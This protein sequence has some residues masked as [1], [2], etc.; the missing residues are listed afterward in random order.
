MKYKVGDKVR[1]VGE[2]VGNNWCP[3]MANN[4]LGKVMTIR[5]VLDSGY[6]MVEDAGEHFDAGWFW[7][8]CMIAG[9]ADESQSKNIKQEERVKYKVGD[10]V[11]IV[12]EKMGGYWDEI[13]LMDRWLNSVMTICEIHHRGLY[14]MEEDNGDWSWRDD[15]IAGLAEE[16]QSKMEEELKNIMAEIAASYKVELGEEFEISNLNNN[17]YKFTERGLFDKQGMRCQFALSDVLCGD[18]PIKKIAWKP[19]DGDGFWFVGLDGGI[20]QANFHKDFIVDRAMLV[21][22]NCFRTYK[23]ADDNADD[24]K[25][26]FSMDY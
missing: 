17:P 26:K 12:S 11:R 3:K 1:I 20:H 22:G 18:L 7:E 21:S 5:E 13:G 10:R 25:E 4:W 15:M 23:E 24:I 9:L 2:E 8:E 14:R 6:R 19:K 16:P